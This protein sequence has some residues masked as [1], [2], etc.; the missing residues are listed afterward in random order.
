[1]R[2]F[3]Y[4]F[5]KSMIKN[6]LVTGASGK[7]GNAVISALAQSGYSIT[8]FTHREKYRSELVTVGAAKV[9][10]GDL[11]DSSALQSALE[12]QHAVYHICPNMTPDE[13]EIGVN[14]IRF[15]EQASIGRFL[16]HSVLHPQIQAMAH[17]WQKLQV[18]EHLF[19]SSLQFTIV[20]P[21]VYMQ[22]WLGY[23]EIISNGSFSMPYQVNAKISFLDLRD[24]GEAIVKII[25]DESTSYGIY[26]LVG[27]YPTSQTRVS[28]IFS[29]ALN[30]EVKAIET[31]KNKWY[32][33]AKQSGMPDYTRDTLYAMFSYY[34]RY[35]LYGSPKTLASLLGREPRSIE[36]FIKEI[37]LTTLK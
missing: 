14:L 4:L 24:L 5:T 6:I 18:E 22:N 2:L 29:S 3:L 15:C 9:L 10:I 7:T 13:C 34:D 8:A 28:E 27:T 36:A 35:G 33:D 30:K 12:C 17:H 31:D 19:Q 20:Q 23:R 16:Y 32:E 21:A 1:V 26:E 25:A 11:R 37:F